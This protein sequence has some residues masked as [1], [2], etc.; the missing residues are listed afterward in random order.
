[1][2]AIWGL[3]HKLPIYRHTDRMKNFSSSLIKTILSFILTLGLVVLLLRQISLRD[4]LSLLSSLTYGWVIVAS[5]FYIITNVGR[6]WRLKIL[7]PNKI[8]R[9]RT[10]MLI[11]IAHAMFN[12][13]LPA[14]TGDF[15]LLY[16]LKRYERAS[17]SESGVALFVARIMDYLAVA[18][19][20]IIAALFSLENFS[21]A[22]QATAIIWAVFGM[23]LLTVV[24]LLLFAWWGQAS[25]FHLQRILDGLG[26]TSWRVVELGLK[27]LRRMIEAFEAIPFKRHFYT[28]LWSL[29]VWGT[30]FVWFFAFMRAM[31]IETSLLITIVG[32]TFAILSKA[33]PFNSVGGLGAHEAGWT[34]GFML[35]GFDKTLAISSGF[36]VNIL[37]LIA[38]VVFGGGAL[39]VL[40]SQS[41]G[42]DLRSQGSSD[43]IRA[44]EVEA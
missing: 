36:A 9:I 35:V 14:R 33:L 27:L 29:F 37:V 40:R 24:L 16:F 10:L 43:G 28:F 17:L 32:A 25:L 34:V 41:S 11:C 44:E 31:G 5:L 22:P 3:T 26:L 12:N 20:F 23:M 21:D 1:M 13:I 42:V 7:L 39:W 19:L 15:S 30:I 2:T 18:V 8:T 6:A 4:V 38:S